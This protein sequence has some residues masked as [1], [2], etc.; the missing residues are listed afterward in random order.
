MG[1]MAGFSCREK[2]LVRRWE[3]RRESCCGA[4]EGS[5]GRR[6]ARLV[7]DS[8]LGSRDRTSRGIGAIATTTMKV[9][10]ARR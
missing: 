6:F 1:T 7:S 5:E 8:R 3:V 2:I 4:M 10:V 9:F